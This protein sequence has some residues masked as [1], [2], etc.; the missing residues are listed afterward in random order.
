MPPHALGCLSN[1]CP[2]KRSPT[3]ELSHRV[4]DGLWQRCKADGEYD[5]QSDLPPRCW[6]E[7]HVRAATAHADVLDAYYDYPSYLSYRKLTWGQNVLA[8]LSEHLGIDHGSSASASSS[9]TTA[10]AH[11]SWPDPDSIWDRLSKGDASWTQPPLAALQPSR[12]IQSDTQLYP[13][14]RAAAAPATGVHDS[15]MSK[16]KAAAVSAQ[17]QVNATTRAPAATAAA[18]VAAI[19][20]VSTL[21]GQ[22]SDD[23]PEE[24]AEDHHAEASQASRCRPQ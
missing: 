23:E 17:A 10:P 3:I 12:T 24:D 1:T 6:L 11:F 16:L 5:E 14:S 2:L 15:A 22:A 8:L 4:R 20:N 21:G 7:H 18:A 13:M 19:A 9:T